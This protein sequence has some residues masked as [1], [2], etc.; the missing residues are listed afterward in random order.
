MIRAAGDAFDAWF[1][2]G[3]PAIARAEQADRIAAM[4]H[5][6]RQTVESV[7]DNV[8]EAL[9]RARCTM[10][11]G[12]QMVVFGSFYTVAEALPL[13]SRNTGV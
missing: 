12:D 4:L 6:E 9:E 5:Q 11:V 1:P 13:M 8:A 10:G 2:A 3:L 7:S